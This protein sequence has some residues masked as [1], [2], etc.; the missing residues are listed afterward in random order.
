M[1]KQKKPEKI[2]TLADGSEGK[3]QYR[4][5]YWY[6]NRNHK[7]SPFGKGFPK[8]ENGSI[9]GVAKQV[10]KGRITKGGCYDRVKG[11]Y[12]WTVE[13]GQ[14]IPGTNVFQPIVTKGEV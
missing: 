9:E 3:R 5:D 2:I 11:E 6:G 13:R 12:L 7:P 4:T 10:M 8:S 1:T 14:R